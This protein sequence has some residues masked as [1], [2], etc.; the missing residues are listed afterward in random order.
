MNDI[1]KNF[2]VEIEKFTGPIY[3]REIGRIQFYARKQALELLIQEFSSSKY[4]VSFTIP[5]I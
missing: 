4:A 3:L 2:S 1:N 5:P